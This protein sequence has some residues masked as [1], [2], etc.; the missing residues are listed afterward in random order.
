[1]HESS[2][3]QELSQI[4]R[5]CDTQQAET[6]KKYKLNLKTNQKHDDQQNQSEDTQIMPID[7][8]ESQDLLA[9]YFE[10]SPDLSP[11]Y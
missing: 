2:S 6:L 8:E 4:I 7:F 3:T 9:D 11:I 10:G 5:E 1:M